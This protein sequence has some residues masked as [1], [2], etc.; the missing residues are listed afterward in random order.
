MTA[1]TLREAARPFT[2]EE[3]SIPP[4]LPDEYEIAADTTAGEIRAL[5]AALAAE[6][7]RGDVYALIAGQRDDA[8]ASVLALGEEVASLR[9]ERDALQKEVYDQETRIIVEGERR[10]TAIEERDAARAAQATAEGERDRAMAVAM[11]AGRR[12]VLAGLD[13]AHAAGLREGIDRARVLWARG[14]GHKIRALLPPD[15][16]NKEKTR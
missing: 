2:Y 10:A 11:E 3:A 9:A 4:E 6:E 15:A 1:P 8:R 14:E 5:R 12:A 16:T 13:A 7:G